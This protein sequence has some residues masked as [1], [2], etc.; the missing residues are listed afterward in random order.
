MSGSFTGSLEL[1]STA[2][3]DVTPFIADLEPGLGAARWDRALD[4]GE[5][6]AVQSPTLITAPDGSAIAFVTVD[7]GFDSHGGADLFVNG[8][9]ADGDL[10]WDHRI[11]NAADQRA[12]GIGV[13]ASGH[14][15]I[16][17]ETAGTISVGDAAVGDAADFMLFVARLDPASGEALAHRHIAGPTLVTRAGNHALAVDSRG[18]VILAVYAYDGYTLGD[19][20][21]P[22]AGGSDAVFVRL[23]PDAAP[24]W[25]HRLG[26]KRNQ[27]GI[28]VLAR[29]G[30]LLFA[31]EFVGS[32]VVGNTSLHAEER[33]LFVLQFRD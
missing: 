15:W 4:L 6:T 3:A 14:V 9:G 28:T 21:E 25:N 17:A 7:G 5:L 24:L 1:G 33:T 20:D 11:G 32:M 10:L 22:G 27:T 29:T 2:S 12:F 31:G 30:G 8:Y 23:D 16:A 19:G 13:G 26:D 18:E